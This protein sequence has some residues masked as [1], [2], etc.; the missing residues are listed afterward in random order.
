[1]IAQKK[2]E[3]SEEKHDVNIELKLHSKQDVGSVSHLG[4]KS[5]VPAY[6]ESVGREFF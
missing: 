1:M 6:S 5:R 4:E 2:Y 3:R